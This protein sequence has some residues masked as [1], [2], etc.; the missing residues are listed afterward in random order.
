MTVTISDAYESLNQPREVE[1]VL[2]I[3]VVKSSL[4]VI[5]GRDVMSLNCDVD[6]LSKRIEVI[7]D[8]EHLLPS[9][10]DLFEGLAVGDQF[11]AAG[12]LKSGPDYMYLQADALYFT[13]AFWH[14]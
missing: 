9:S 7:A 4:E 8:S 14:K 10:M 1:D 3:C 11:V 5:Q 12:T 2:A 13:S 6:G